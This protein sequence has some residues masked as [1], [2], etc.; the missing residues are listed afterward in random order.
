MVCSTNDDICDCISDPNTP[1][2]FNS[3][4][5]DYFQIEAGLC[6]NE[7]ILDAYYRELG[8]Y[9]YIDGAPSPYLVGACSLGAG[10]VTCDGGLWQQTMFCVSSICENQ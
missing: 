1:Q 5:I 9:V 7:N 4:D 8:W 6:G 10:F 3:D 2:T